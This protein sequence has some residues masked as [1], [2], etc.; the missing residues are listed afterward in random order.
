MI[1]NLRAG[2]KWVPGTIM[3]RIGPLSYLVQV[4]GIQM[5]KRHID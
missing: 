2:D 5:W 1:R 3:E 4:A